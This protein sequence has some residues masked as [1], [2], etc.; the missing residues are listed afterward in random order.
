MASDEPVIR[1]VEISDDLTVALF[2]NPQPP[3]DGDVGSDD[4]DDPRYGIFDSPF[5]VIFMI[6]VRSDSDVGRFAHDNLLGLLLGV[7][8]PGDNR[9]PADIADRM[10]EIFA[11]FGITADSKVVLLR[12]N[13]E[14]PAN[15][16]RRSV[17]GAATKNPGTIAAF[18]WKD[19]DPRT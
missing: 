10:R 17:I 12:A 18:D 3:E 5:A 4:P 8:P 13:A 2:P 14:L 19:K 16:K 9:L 15:P 7:A 1:W 11:P 6:R